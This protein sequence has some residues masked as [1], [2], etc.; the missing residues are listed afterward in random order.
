M[1]V[2]LCPVRG[3]SKDR[4][5]CGVGFGCAQEIGS[6]AEDAMVILTVGIRIANIY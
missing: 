2:V 1:L 3:L 4:R 6:P 5:A